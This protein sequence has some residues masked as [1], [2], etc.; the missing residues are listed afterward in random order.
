[1]PR[2]IVRRRGLSLLAASGAAA[3][4]GLNWWRRAPKAIK[5]P[6]PP[7]PRRPWQAPAD[8]VSGVP[9][10]LFGILGT[11]QSLSVGVEGLPVL[12]NSRAEG[13]FQ[14]RLGA[15]SAGPYDPEDAELALETLHEPLRELGRRYPAPYPYN[16]NGE[17]PHTALA[18][19]WGELC[20]QHL[21]RDCSTVHSV[22]GE[23]G[24][25]M[26]VIER[27]AHPT[28]DTGH[29]WAASLFEAR[30]IARL[31]REA[32]K[33]FGMG[34]ILLTHGESD[35][36]RS[37]YAEELVRFWR[38]YNADL[39]A[40]TG[41]TKAIPLFLTQ[42][43]SVPTLPGSVSASTLAAWRVARASGGN[44]VCV[45]PRYQYVYAADQVH[46]TAKSY[47]Q[48]GEKSAQVI[49]QHVAQ[50][51]PF[52]PLEPLS[53]ERRGPAFAIVF[54]VPVPPLR[55][56]E[57]LRVP[58]EGRGFQLLNDTAVL[59]LASVEL[60]GPDTVLIT[61]RESQPGPVTL[62]Y[63]LS[64]AAP[65]PGGTLRSGQ[66]CDSDPFIGAHTRLPQ[67]NYAV[68]FELLVPP[69]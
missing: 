48:L 29:A 60:A 28:R 36:E 64:A 7:P 27:D 65:R 38:D 56:D 6:S 5:P 55:W 2:G 8:R 40:I 17:T 61:P 44:I 51:R 18:I 19:Q 62:R 57:S 1:M 39:S 26:K 16:I 67:P 41:Q 45:G 10:D 3:A 35:A 69:T 42:Q 53:I 63:A 14:L 43:C 11:G 34:A 49:F 15:G 23:S 9:W 68:C 58:G 20:R 32:G 66:L 33:T 12:A 21:G 13:H 30:A 50:A 4:L 37:E 54:H 31:A 24:M 25:G 22:V 46:L 52:Q 59:P 47:A